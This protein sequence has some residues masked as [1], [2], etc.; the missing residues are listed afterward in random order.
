MSY[1]TKAGKGGSAAVRVDGVGRDYEFIKVDNPRPKVRRITL[2]RPKQMNALSN[3]LRGEL[4]HALHM[5]DIDDSVHVTIIRGNEKAFSA[6]YDLK[7]DLSKDQPFYTAGGIANWPR[8]V[9][10]GCF[11][12]WDLA[13]PVVAEVRGYCL[14]GGMELAQSCDLVYVAEDA[15]IGYPV[16]RSLSPPDNHFFPWIFGMRKAM[17]IMLTGD[18]LSGVEAVDRGFANRAFPAEQLEESVLAIAERMAGIPIDL[19]QFNK[20]GVHR[21]MEL[22]GMRAAIRMATDSEELACHTKT[23]S[24]WIQSMQEAGLNQALKD[25]D[26]KFG[27][28]SQKEK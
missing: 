10:E 1:S 23:S 8:H 21:Q 26:G 7:S 5:A 28:L 12:I 22:M 6:G 2:N 13:K 24:A 9:V 15:Q 16:V 19:Q 4:F 3:P 25:R 14:A 18:P 20:R 27:D 17:E 11:W